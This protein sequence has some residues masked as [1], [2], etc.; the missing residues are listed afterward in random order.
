VLKD[1]RE[2]FERFG[3]FRALDSSIRGKRRIEMAIFITD[4]GPG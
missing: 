4:E 3:E 2:N 1:V